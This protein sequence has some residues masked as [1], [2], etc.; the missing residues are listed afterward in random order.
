[1]AIIAASLTCLTAVPPPGTVNGEVEAE[2]CLNYTITC[3]NGSSSSGTMC[4]KT[5]E[6]AKAKIIAMATIACSQ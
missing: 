6:L 3:D 4:A 5:Y 1:M 2:V